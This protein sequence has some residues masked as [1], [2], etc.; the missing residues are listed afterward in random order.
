MVETGIGKLGAAREASLL[1]F[2]PEGGLASTAVEWNGEK[3]QGMRLEQDIVDQ[4]IPIFET[5]V[6]K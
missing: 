1:I 6:T 2:C 3:P 5:S 4:D